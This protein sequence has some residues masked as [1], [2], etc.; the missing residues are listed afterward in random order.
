MRFFKRKKIDVLSPLD[1]YNLWASFYQ[2]ESNPIKSQSDSLV[3][4]FTPDLQ[5]KAVLDAGCGTGRFCLYAETQKA[6]KVTGIDLSPN[7]IEQAGKNCISTRLQ[8]ADLAVT[9]L[10]SGTFDVIICALVLGHIET[11]TQTL[12]NLIQSLT[13]NGVLII[14][15]FHPFLTLIQSKRTFQIP[16]SGQQFEVRHHL[17]LFQEYFQVC[18]NHGLSIEA[19]EERVFQN[20]P[21]VFGMRLRKV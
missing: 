14:T 9:P 2:A 1:G 8:C 20:V 21:V 15:D 16:G 19:F 4:K 12:E 6:A 7:M 11:L 13:S 5:G 3:E 18:I 17:H 10:E